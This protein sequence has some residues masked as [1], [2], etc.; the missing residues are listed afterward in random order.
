MASIGEENGNRRILFYDPSGKRKTVRLGKVSKRIAETAKFHIEGLLA[1][2]TAGHSPE[3]ET[4]QWLA[5]VDD[6]IYKRLVNVGLVS[7]T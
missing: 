4:A 5:G 1:A 3:R 7:A 2:K 6:I